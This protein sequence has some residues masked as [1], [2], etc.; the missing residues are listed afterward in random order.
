VC[1]YGGGEGGYV[2]TT[3]L[4]D[5]GRPCNA[6]PPTKRPA[7]ELPSQ[8]TCNCSIARKGWSAMQFTVQ[9]TPTGRRSRQPRRRARFPRKAAKCEQ[10]RTT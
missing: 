2:R 10:K 9:F 4:L 1:D 7:R 3:R 5:K 6:M 8:S